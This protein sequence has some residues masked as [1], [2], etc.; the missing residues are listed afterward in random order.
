MEGGDDMDMD[1][2]GGDD[3][4]GAADAA[5]GGEAPM[6][7]EKRESATPRGNRIKEGKV[8]DAMMD[9]SEKM[10][11]AE[12]A[13]KYGNDAADEMYESVPRY[14]KKKLR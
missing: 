1:M 2:E 8:K 7:R 12:F 10:T 3:E 9:D 11:K 5:S 4:F 14:S 13:K 6:G